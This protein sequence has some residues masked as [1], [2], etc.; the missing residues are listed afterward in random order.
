VIW[1]DASLILVN[2][3]VNT[4]AKLNKTP[5]G[6]GVEVD[7]R[8]Y[9]DRIIL[10]HEPFQDGVDFEEFLK[11]YRH[12]LLIL[13]TKSEGIEER[14]L[15]LVHKHGIE[16]YFLLDVTFPF[17][18][19]YINKG[20]RKMAVRFSEYESIETCLK[21]KGKVDWVFVDNLTHLPIEGN[22]LAILG[23]HFKICVV[24][25]ELL[26]RLDEKEL[27][28]KILKRYPVDAMLTDDCGGWE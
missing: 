24:A 23:R 20:I 10:N 14:A 9:Q 7:L 11:H 1:G 5:T 13:N 26:K 4:I 8:P 19:K 18:V 15:A 22:A 2:H 17:I 16:N 21:L 27:T 3:R 6:Y 25:P 28:K 12:A